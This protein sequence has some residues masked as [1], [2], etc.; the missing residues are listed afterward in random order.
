MPINKIYMHNKM[1][2]DPDSI[3]KIVSPLR[4]SNYK[5]II[6]EKS[7]NKDSCVLMTNPYINKYT[8]FRAGTLSGY[9][10]RDNSI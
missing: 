2:N 7:K 4:F 3:L 9:I 1:A 5:K 6:K 10:L 8:F